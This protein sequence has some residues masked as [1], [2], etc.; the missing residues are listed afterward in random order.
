VW[1]VRTPDFLTLS[2]QHQPRPCLKR[3][4]NFNAAPIQIVA[5]FNLQGL[6]AKYDV[7][8]SNPANRLSTL[9]TFS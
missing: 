1:L 5:R 6:A 9:G 7:R 8:S 4:K 2:K 3:T